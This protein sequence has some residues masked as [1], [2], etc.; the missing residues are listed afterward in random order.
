MEEMMG[1]LKIAVLFPCDEAQK[2][3][4]AEAGKGQCEFW[5]IDRQ[6]PREERL[7][8]LRQAEVIFG[9]PGIREIQNCPRL[10]WVQMSWAGTDVYTMREGFPE[11]VKLTN[12]RGCFQTVIAEYIMAVLLAMCRNLK[13]YARQQQ[14][15]CWKQIGK[16]ILISGKNALILG[17]GDIGTGAARRLK[18]FGVHVTGMR[19]TDRNYPDCYDTMI[20]EEGLDGVLPGADIVIGCLPFTKET[21]GLLYEERLRKMKKTALLINVGRGNLIDTEAL[22][23][24]LKEGHLGGVALDVTDPEPLPAAHPLWKI[25]RVLLT[26]H[27]A[28]QSFGYSKETENKV[29]HICCQNLERYLGGKELLN[30]VDFEKGYATV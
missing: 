30:L 6:M 15:E 23:K 24:V 26:P 14:E 12:A 4:L 10:K 5:Y 20:T 29:L 17:A 22:V 21:K 3:I 13:Q 2:R 18:A 9:E 1:R 19:R 7:P 16:E 8:V 25:E 28:G 11:K 27:I